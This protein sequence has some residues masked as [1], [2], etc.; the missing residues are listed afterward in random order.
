MIFDPSQ[1]TIGQVSS[2]IRDFTIVA[3]LLRLAW[4]ARGAY[5]A[6]MEFIQRLKRFM[7]R[8]EKNSKLTNAK[9]D[10]LLSNHL[11]H[12]EGDLA[13]LAERKVAPKQEQENA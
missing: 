4:G 3:V 11:K 8:M 12:I 2:T 10:L 1:L 6:A 13:V 9:L 7:V 5:S